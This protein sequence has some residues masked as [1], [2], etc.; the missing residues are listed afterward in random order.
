MNT[1]TPY[2]PNQPRKTLTLPA[3]KPQPVPA[4]IRR[5]LGFGLVAKIDCSR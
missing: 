4:D 1:P 2:L 3:P 5:A